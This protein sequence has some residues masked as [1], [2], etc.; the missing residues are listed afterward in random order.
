MAARMASHAD[1]VVAWSQH[2][3]RSRLSS[4]TVAEPALGTRLAG[5]PTWPPAPDAAGHIAALQALARCP[6][7]PQ[8]AGSD[9]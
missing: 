5:R 1:P 3:R 7:R 9:N 8:T 4:T 2:T 6:R